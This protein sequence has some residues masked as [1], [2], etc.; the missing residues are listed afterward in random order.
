MV[1]DTYSGTAIGGVLT[2]T[3]GGTA[4]V[5]AEIAF[6]GHYVTSN[7]HLED[8]G[9]GHV[10]IVDPSA[11]EPQPSIA[12]GA[13]TTLGYSESRVQAGGFAMASN[14]AAA[15][16]LLGNYMAGS[17]ATAASDHGGTLISSP[18]QTEQWSLLAHPHE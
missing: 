9:S 1:S 17:F 18:P 7:F 2:V 11:N 13:A 4:N 12:Y 5:V 16:A 6:T 8:D 14:G 10:K 15:I 3:S